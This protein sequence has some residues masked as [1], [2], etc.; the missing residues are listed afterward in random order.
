MLSLR[1]DTLGKAAPRAARRTVASLTAAEKRKVQ[2]AKRDAPLPEGYFFN[3]TQYMSLADGERTRW[4]PDLERFLQEHVDELNRQ[5]GLGA[6]E[7]ADGGVGAAGAAAEIVVE[8]VERPR[9]GGGRKTPKRPTSG[10][11]AGPRPPS[12]RPPSVARPT[13]AARTRRQLPKPPPAS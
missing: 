6:G 2:E 13:S 1:R 11:P 10:R 5:A 7:G 3:G 12:A 8:R 4:H 9:T